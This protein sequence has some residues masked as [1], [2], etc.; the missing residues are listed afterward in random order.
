MANQFIKK[1]EIPVFKKM[2]NEANSF[3]LCLFPPVLALYLLT[4]F[5]SDY[6]KLLSPERAGYVFNG[7]ILNV[8]AYA[9]FMFLDAVIVI[10]SI[11]IFITNLIYRGKR[12]KGLENNE[13]LFLF[14]VKL[15]GWLLLTVSFLAVALTSCVFASEDLTFFYLIALVTSAVFYLD[16]LV[17]IPITIVYYA[18]LEIMPH[19]FG[20]NLTYEPYMPYGI[21]FILAI[22]LISLF[23]AYY[24][25]VTL[26]RE[27][28]IQDLRENADRQNS[29]KSM[30]LA[31]MSHEIRTPMNAIVGMSELAMDF[32]LPPSKKNTI[33]QIRS[34]GIA[35]VGIINDILDFSKIES[36]KMEIVCD[37]YD[38]LKMLYDVGNV[39][40]VK[41]QGKKV[42]LKIKIDPSLPS[43]VSGDDLRIRQVLINL[44][45]NAVKFTDTGSVTISAEKG[46]KEG[47]IR[48]SVTDTGIGI[49][50]DDLEK[51]FAE[52]QQVDM[53]M[54]R[55][56]GGTGLGLSISKNLVR[57]M[58]GS[59]SVESEYGKGSVFYFDIPQ[60]S[61][62]DISTG[63]KYPDVFTLEQ[64]NGI[65]MSE[66]NRPEIAGLFA[67]SDELEKISC[68]DAKVLIVDDNELNIEVAQGFLE[69]FNVVPD[70]ALSGLETLEKLE[71]GKK[72]H[73][74]FMDHQMPVMDGVEVLKKI[75]SM[76]AEGKSF[77]ADSE[78]APCTVIA[79]TANAVSESV[80]MFMDSGFNG[81][82]AKPVQGKD[83]AD[84]L[85]KWIP[86]NLISEC[87]SV[88]EKDSDKETK[89][90]KSL[91]K[92]F[93]RLLE[94]SAKEI[95]DFLEK[96][97]MKNYTIKVHA[98]KSSAKIVG[99]QKLSDLAA[100]LEYLGNHLDS[101]DA[102]NKIKEKTPMLLDMY[103]SCGESLRKNLEDDDTK[104]AD[105]K[106]SD[107]KEISSTV[108][109]EIKQE[110]LEACS[111]ND[112]NA[113]DSALEKLNGF[114]LKE[115]DKELLHQLEDAAEMIDFDEVSRIIKLLGV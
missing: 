24:I 55:S 66:L 7:L 104:K 84:A 9:I 88:P 11:C 18:L 27:K 60:Q 68:P 1:S 113:L 99:D 102:L 76:E 29:L 39:C 110:I 78:K 83:F 80:K 35:L 59:L 50:K 93:L 8:N 56:K 86:Q 65:S 107:L 6:R 48:F 72:Y 108:F 10:S 36:G 105:A 90:E 114:T 87:E 42:D 21:F 51:I 32:D 47:T 67:D 20:W 57:L 69:K 3:R 101:D 41:L 91:I 49:K 100:E 31:N 109:Q 103:R 106:D 5:I 115:G 40:L 52:F 61:V 53:K 92:T 13:N 30:F 45:G 4:E 94:P 19:V 81:F 62:S 74:I 85:V 95:N 15:Y 28:E 70:T 25:L 82:I 89:T 26:R 97:D 34:S 112:L 17:M 46:E 44:T 77:R 79:F 96:G 2:I 43:E 64:S 14:L 23:R 98:L 75:R 63:E 58:G 73:I 33:R 38:L 22:S 111:H 37:D 12:K 54:N 16:C 71:Q